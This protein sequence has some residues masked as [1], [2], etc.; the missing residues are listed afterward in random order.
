MR[1]GIAVANVDRARDTIGVQVHWCRQ[2]SDYA[3]TGYGGQSRECAK[4]G[5][6]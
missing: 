5:S 4:G 2:R 1:H 6:Q 3:D